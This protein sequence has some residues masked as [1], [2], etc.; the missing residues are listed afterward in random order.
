MR[1]IDWLQALRRERSPKGL[2]FLSQSSNRRRSARG[3]RRNSVETLEL[4]TLLSGVNQG[5]FAD[6]GQSLGTS[7]SRE[8]ALGDLDGDGDLDAIVANTSDFVEGDASNQVWLN[9]GSGTFINSG[10]SLGSTNTL[11]IDLADF[12]GDGDLDAF[13]SGQYRNEP[14]TVW[15][16]DSSGTFFDSGQ[17]LGGSFSV[18]VS[19]GDLDGDGDIDVFV[20]NNT[21]P[22]T[23]LLNDGSGVFTANG[24]SDIGPSTSSLDVSL[25][26]VDGDGDLDA[27][28]VNWDHPDKVWLNNGSGLFSD[29]GQSLGDLNSRGISLGDIDGD[30]DLDAFVANYT[31]GYSGIPNTVWLNNGSGVFSD[32]GQELGYHHSRGVDLADL[33]DDG[34]LDAFVT[35]RNGHP[36]KVWVNNG[37]GT[38]FDSGQKMGSFDTYEAALGD[39]DADGDLDAFTVNRYEGNRVWINDGTAVTTQVRINDFYAEGGQ[40]VSVFYTILGNTD[41]TKIDLNFYRSA[42]QSFD[43]SAVLLDSI[44]VTTPSDLTAGDHNLVF[45]LGTAASKINLPGFGVSET[46]ADYHLLVVA[47]PEIPNPNS[48]SSLTSAADLESFLG[49]PAQSLDTLEDDEGIGSSV[50]EGSAIKKTFEGTAGQD[51]FISFNFLTPILSLR[52]VLQSG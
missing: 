22:S 21:D 9:D 43:N 20:A 33:D 40:T 25:G 12:D 47:D 26:D 19:L 17:S 28:V 49:L 29:S 52:L 44:A 10:Q 51:L 38:F 16:N 5:T 7:F 31:D 30:G 36:N 27:F 8:A 46:N 1:L 50:I 32:T 34:D 45:N 23:V 39:L 11:G 15:L 35:N 24:Q 13:V 14:N 2:H 4:R 42:L 48:T 41:P 3:L 18:G 6:S 37:S